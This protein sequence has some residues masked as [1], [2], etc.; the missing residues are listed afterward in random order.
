M[1]EPSASPSPDFA[2]TRWSVVRAAG[3][4]S[5]QA[6][7]QALEVLCEAYWHPL[8]SYVRRQGESPEDAADLTQGFFAR[9]LE[10][11]HLHALRPE[12]G[13]FRSYLLGAM[14]HFLA[15]EWDRKRAQRRG[16]GR[17]TLPLD[18]EA[19]EGRYL[20]EPTHDLTPE[21]I[22]ERGWAIALLDR[23]LTRLRREMEADGMLGHFDALK[24]SL[25][26]G[27]GPL[28]SET[29]ARLGMTEAAVKQAA[30]RL[31]RRYRELLRDEIAHTVTGPDEVDDEIRC[32]FAALGG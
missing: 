17:P 13:K 16:G 22:Y 23:V 12:Q 24:F 3:G 4:G 31:R 28:H 6:S 20:R 8:Y 18:F 7:R 1:K 29:A 14:K 32:L 25:S 26:G 27:G 30:H 15:N 21:R 2:T 19:A 11:E 5:T 9:F 10:K